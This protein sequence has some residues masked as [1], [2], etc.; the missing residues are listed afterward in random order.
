MPTSTDMGALGSSGADPSEK[1]V[2][3][4]R[5]Y[6]ASP[7]MLVSFP[8]STQWTGSDL[9]EQTSEITGDYHMLSIS[10][11]P[12]EFSIWLGRTSIPNKEVIPGTIQLTPP[13]VPARIIYHKAYDALHV[14]IQN[15]LLKE[16]FELSFGMS[17]KGDVV[18]HDPNYAHDPLIGRLGVALL[19]ADELGG[20]CGELYADALSLAIV[21]RLFALYAEKPDSTSQRNVASLP[22][23]RL[24]RTID[25]I[26]SHADEP[27]TLA[28]LARTAGLS[29]MHFAAQFRKATGLRPHEY[30]LRQRV[31]K[32]K[33]MLRT[34]H[35]P[36][37]EIALA[38][39]FGSQAHFTGVFKRFAGETPHRWRECSRL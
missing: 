21:A 8:P 39:G 37:V 3:T 35:L 1:S 36:I 23:W 33:T 29:R 20:S 5:E 6:G 24:K 13:G 26:D 32:A 15:S 34:T 28:D 22:N 4:F 14:F 7:A 11:E 10:L 16:L 18:L 17:P 19:S 31:E 25:F 30:L 12:T 9:R 27:I 2:I 38:V